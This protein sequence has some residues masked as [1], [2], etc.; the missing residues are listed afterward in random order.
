LSASWRA[1]TA[2]DSLQG[3]ATGTA[4]SVAT[5]FGAPIFSIPGSVGDGRMEMSLSAT[6]DHSLFVFTPAA[7]TGRRR[8]TRQAGRRRRGRGKEGVTQLTHLNDGVEPAWGKSVSLT[9]RAT[10]FNVQ[11]W[12]MLPKDYDPAKKYPLIVEVHGGPASAVMAQWGG[13]GLSAR[14]FRRWATL[15]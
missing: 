3:R 10:R 13:G 8:F 9:G 12:L 1:A 2:V 6:A 14:H 4:Q 15:C 7:S 5:S 11:G